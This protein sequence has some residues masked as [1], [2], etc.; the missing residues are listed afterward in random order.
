MGGRGIINRLETHIKNGLADFIPKNPDKKDI[1]LSV[2][3]DKVNF[4]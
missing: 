3:G 1:S 2:V 4:I